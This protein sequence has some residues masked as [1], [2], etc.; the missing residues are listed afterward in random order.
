MFCFQYLSYLN[1]KKVCSIQKLQAVFLKTELNLLRGCYF[2]CFYEYL[3]CTLNGNFICTKY[4]VLNIKINSHLSSRSTSLGMF[5]HYVR[6]SACYDLL[7]AST[8][9]AYINACEA[10]SVILAYCWCNIWKTLIS[11]WNAELVFTAQVRRTNL[12]SVLFVSFAL[13]ILN[14]T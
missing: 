7:P 10:A 8:L 2:Y 4:F 11:N 1:W 6:Y 5:K 3:V 9:K 13:T 14:K 12:V